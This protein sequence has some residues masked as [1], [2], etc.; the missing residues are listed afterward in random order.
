MDK[1]KRGLA[2][3]ALAVGSF[4]ITYLICELFFFRLMLPL[5]KAP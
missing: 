2:N 1:L 4:L 3:T 5:P